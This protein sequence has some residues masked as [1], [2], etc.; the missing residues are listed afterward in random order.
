MLLKKTNNVQPHSLNVN[1]KIMNDNKPIPIKFNN[2]FGS[3]ANTIGHFEG[4]TEVQ[5]NSW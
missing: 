1:G 4:Q 5:L 2:F 3:I